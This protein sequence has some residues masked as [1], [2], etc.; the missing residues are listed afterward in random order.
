MS[1]NLN[2]II[3]AAGQG[4][5]M[6]SSL[7][8]V[9]HKLGGKALLQHVIDTAQALFPKNIYIIYGYEGEKIKSAFENIKYNKLNWVYQEK[10]LGTAHAVMQVLP[11]LRNSD[12]QVLILYG[13]VALISL[14]TLH[15][16]LQ[17]TSFNQLGLLTVNLE[18]P[19]GLGRIIRDKNNK[20]I[21]I[22]EEK[23]ATAEEKQIKEINP[24]IYLTTVKYLRKILPEISAHN[25]QQEYYLTDIVTVQSDIV[26]INIENFYEVY[27]VNDLE[28][29][30]ILECYYQ[31]EL[32]KKLRLSGVIIGPN[33]IFEGNIT[34]GSGSQIGANCI[35]RDV[36]IGNNTEIKANS[37]IEESVIGDHCKIG[38]FA[39]IRP[40]TEL[41]SQVTVGNFVEIKNSQINSKSK[42]PH[43]SYV[44]DTTMGEN[45]NF[46][47]GAITCN[48]DGVNK[49]RTIIEN[50]VF[51]GSDSQL[52]APVKIEEGSIIGAGSTITKDTPANKLTLARARQQTIDRWVRSKKILEK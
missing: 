37:I 26:D 14:Q 19:A 50:N 49:Y 35:L 41:A 11:M 3:L 31:A 1:Q 43:L 36:N 28:Q 27:G 42:I 51:I 45:V 47:A 7:P 15:A 39:R 34:I 2:I 33:V 16:L 32:A 12:E 30:Y 52:I 17:K 23:E 25:A 46:G 9:L 13:D 44:G 29:L 6:K 22:T 18:N 5:R 48:Y 8:K 10:Q 40:G 20:V 4:T 24:G 38:P 21:K